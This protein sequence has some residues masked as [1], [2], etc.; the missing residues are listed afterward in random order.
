MKKSAAFISIGLISGIFLA[1]FMKMM[2][3]F[4][5]NKAF[6]LL[7]DVDYVPLLNQ[8]HPNWMTGLLFHFGTCILS[9]SVLYYLLSYVHLEKSPVA[10]ALIIGIGSAGLFFLTALSTKTPEITDMEAWFYWVLGHFLFSLS[11]V[12]LIRRW[13]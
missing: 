8:L 13:L 2:Q 9:L 10:Y 4:T 6:Y 1:L 5:G 7:F 11:S 3:F 12:Y